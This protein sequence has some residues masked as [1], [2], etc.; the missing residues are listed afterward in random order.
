MQ[1]VRRVVIISSTSSLPRHV[2]L[3]LLVYLRTY[4]GTYLVYLP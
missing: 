2:L 3:V 1:F 4:L